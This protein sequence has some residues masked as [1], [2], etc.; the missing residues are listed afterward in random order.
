[1]TM[2]YLV[3]GGGG[4]EHALAQVISCDP[5]A[6]LYAVNSNNNPGIASLSRETLV[7]KETDVDAIVSYA[8]EMGIDYAVI[9]PEAPLMAG[10]VDA[11]LEIGIGCLGPTQAAARIETDKAFCRRLMKEYQIDGLPLYRIFDDHDEAEA[12][13]RDHGEDLVIKPIGLTG[14]KGV[15]V[16]G[17]HVDQ[18][19]AIEYLRSIDGGVVI[20]ERLLGEEFTMMA[21]A[22]GRSLFPMPLV[23]DHK[24][25]F[26]GDTGPNTGGMGSYSL[27]DH[28]LPFVTDAD[29]AAALR[30]MHDVVAA[31][32]HSGTT[33]RGILYG[34]FMNTAT[35]PK[36]IEFNARFGD[37]EAMNV[38][39]ILSSGFT[40]IIARVA[41][42]TLRQ[43]DVRFDPKATVCKY[44][45][46]A[47]YPD[48]PVAGDPIGLP[49]AHDARLY[50]AN[51]RPDHGTIYTQ[52]SRSL[53]F[54]GVG[55]TLA[56]AERSAESAA[57]RVT[58]N[59]RY[60]SDIGREE[61]VARRI[62]HM[63][64]IR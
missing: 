4:R 53:A 61:I 14:G 32:D 13:I 63:K 25:A 37:P 8:K 58:G 23:Q 31:L 16:M 36:V 27:P 18:A 39:S 30:I 52:S 46:P 19:G 44:V 24:R 40:E 47:G 48:A 2:K 28:S 62:A 64:E 56:D 42:G 34:Q 54:V 17:E 20:E 57:S 50:F 6:V 41:D 33:Y 22:D 26:E 10:L 49:A 60:R 7:K 15:K 29:Y 45:V 3:V 11:L 35:G 12:F 1:M 38:L 5:E 43:S 9:G 59:V 55:D 51:V 21:F